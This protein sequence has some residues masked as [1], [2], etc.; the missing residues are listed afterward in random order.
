MGYGMT[1]RGFLSHSAMGLAAAAGCRRMRMNPVKLG[2]VFPAYTDPVTGA[3][4]FML[5]ND[6]AKDDVIYQTHP[7]WTPDMAHL[8]FKSDRTGGVMLPHALA[9]DTGEVRPLVR[10]GKTPRFTLTWRTATLFYIDGREV[11]RV[12]VEAAYAG[13]QQPE[14]VAALPE[15]VEMLAGSLS[16]NAGET[17]LYAGAQLKADKRWAVYALDLTSGSWS[18]AA[19]VDFQVGHVQANPH[20][21][22][23]VLFCHETGGYAPQRMW[24]LDAG[25]RSCR[26]LYESPS[27]EWVTHEVWWGPERVIFTIWPYDE[28]H[29][30]QAHGVCWSA[31]ADGERRLLSQYPA[32]HTHGSPDGRWAMG[33]DF[34]RNIW[35]I[36]ADSGARRLLTQGHSAGGHKTHPHGSFTPDS[37]GIVFNSSRNETADIYL[38]ALPAWPQLPETQ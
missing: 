9:M 28:A 17:V 8:V 18:R 32:W 3:Q 21:D 10:A 5:T 15:D 20:D 30:Q 7:M 11:Y 14:R 23:Y 12:S 2:K 35:L 19:T 1:R 22:R 13:A 29:K 38:V 26:P 34:D 31:I 25:E 16:V 6:A 36:D 33:D 24:L 4:V 27:K 37:R